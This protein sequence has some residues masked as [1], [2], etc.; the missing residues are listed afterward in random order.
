MHTLYE[1]TY[2]LEEKLC[3]HWGNHLIIYPSEDSKTAEF[4]FKTICFIFYK[5]AGIAFAVSLYKVDSKAKGGERRYG[6]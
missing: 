6:K 4:L 5:K 3:F 1:I 2:I